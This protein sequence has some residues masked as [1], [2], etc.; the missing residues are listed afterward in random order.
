MNFIGFINEYKKPIIGSIITASIIGFATYVYQNV[1]FPN[2]Y[3]TGQWVTN[4]TTKKTN[5]KAYKDGVST[6]VLNI[7][8]LP[9]NTITGSG[10]KIKDS[11][12]DGVVI[13]YET[14]QR[15]RITF[16]GT[17]EQRKF[18]KA[19]VEIAATNYGSK[20]TTTAH[21]KLEVLN[22]NSIRGTYTTTIA[23]G[24]G[25]MEMKKVE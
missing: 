13:K 17:I 24:S 8:Q 10:E 23:H 15:D 6:Y 1:L 2:R 7:I 3:I 4:M 25:I 16:K 9:D 22:E 19:V 12:A 21:F 18:G 20:Y 11:T 5:Y 14:V